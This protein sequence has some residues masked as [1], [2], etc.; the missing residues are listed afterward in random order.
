MRLTNIYNF[1]LVLYDK[2]CKGVKAHYFNATMIQ[3]F[4]GLII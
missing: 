2:W 3:P 4:P 1:N